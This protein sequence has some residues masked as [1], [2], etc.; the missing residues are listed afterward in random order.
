MSSVVR[1]ISAGICAAWSSLRES[2]DAALNWWKRFGHE[3]VNPNGMT[4]SC[5]KLNFKSTR[6]PWDCVSRRV[7][8]PFMRNRIERTGDDSVHVFSVSKEN[9]P[10][11]YIY[12]SL[13][14]VDAASQA[15]RFRYRPT[16][17]IF[18]TI[19]CCLALRWSLWSL[20]SPLLKPTLVPSAPVGVLKRSQ[21]YV[22]DSAD[23]CAVSLR[24]RDSSKIFSDDYRRIA[25]PQ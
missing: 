11:R 10:Y 14:T 3:I 7:Y 19:S 8:D 2:F 5:I 20:F 12:I 16:L 17:L 22:A 13:N 4:H 24:L 18:H 15:S 23:A 1:L 25:D 9:L 21:D 6:L